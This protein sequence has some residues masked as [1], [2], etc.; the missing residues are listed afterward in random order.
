M[1][2]PKVLFICKQ[3]PAQ[4][5]ASYG[6]LN[7]CKFISNALEDMGVES[8]VIEVIDNNYIDKE[9]HNYKPTHCFIEALWVVPEKFD[10]LI[11]LHPNIQWFVRIH[12][13]TPFLANE[14]MAMDWIY[15]Y[16]LLQNKY[17]QF[18]LSPN[19]SDMINDIYNIFSAITVY[20]PNIYYPII[21]P[22]I[23]LNK[24][25]EKNKYTLEIGCFGA[26]RPFK[27]QLL[28]AMAAISFANSLN[29]NLRF[30]INHTRVETHGE[31]VH[32]NLV[33]LFT[34]TNHELVVHDWLSH[35]DFLRLIKTMDMGLQ[36]SFSETFNIVAADFVNLN[37]PIIGSKEISW[38][39][40][41]YQAN[42]NNIDDITKAM[43]IA[44][45]CKSFNLQYLNKLGLKHWNKQ[46]IVTW[47]KLLNI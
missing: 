4:Y 2:T 14:G 5:G 22:D 17:K 7:S 28:Q 31:A 19:S 30:H 40:S 45:T 15:K 12:S 16:L 3:R 23:L 42:P 37:V 34:N 24:P 6:L 13:N 39:N 36:V 1:N 18:H 35:D 11:P 33:S 26:I 21:S 9:C 47:K 25:V 41:F 29:K 43:W 27:N 32:K 44:W 20:T 8:K 10:V 38:L 46:A